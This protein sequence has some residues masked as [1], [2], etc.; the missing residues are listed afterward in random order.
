MTE[1]QDPLTNA[2]NKF[3]SYI[4]PA[5]KYSGTKSSSFYVPMKDGVEL[6]V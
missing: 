3:G 2:Q 1:A 4:P 5:A 6:A